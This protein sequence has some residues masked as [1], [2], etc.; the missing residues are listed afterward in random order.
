[1]AEI[2]IECHLRCYYRVR[3]Q[4]SIRFEER[5]LV[6]LG[7][8][9]LAVAPLTYYMA[10]TIDAVH[11]HTFK[12]GLVL[13]C[14]AIAVALIAYISV[15]HR[16]VNAECDFGEKCVVFNPENENLSIMFD[17]GALP[18]FKKFWMEIALNN[19]TNWCLIGGRLSNEFLEAFRDREHSVPK[20]I[21]KDIAIQ[22]SGI[23]EKDME[24][25]RNMLLQMC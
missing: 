20:P 1:M 19:D 6:L 14:V 18:V 23:E 4:S 3:K 9:L 11:T 7:L 5:M 16:V 25:L 12:T 2:R 10:T 13:S 21:R 17:D 15:F 8:L 22:L 24:C